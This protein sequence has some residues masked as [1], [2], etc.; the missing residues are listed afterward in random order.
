MSTILDEPE[1]IADLLERL[2]GIDPRRIPLRPRPGEAVE[3]DVVAIRDRTRRICELVDGTL[4]EKVIG[5]QESWIAATLIRLIGTYVVAR[6]LGIVTAPDGMLRLS[7]GLV[8]IP[9]VAFIAWSRL[10]GRAIPK[11][12]IPDLVPDLAVE[13]LSE[14]NTAREI[15]RKVDEYFAAGVR[16]VWLIDPRQ[17]RATALTSPTHA[18]TLGE[19]D[20]LDGGDVLPGFRVPLADLFAGR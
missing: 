1:T 8:R 20:F 18:V 19:S 12:P 10:P 3:A 2:G 15:S 17:R 14:G 9:D 16:L 7:R 13:V 11:E 6:D 4:V 5:F